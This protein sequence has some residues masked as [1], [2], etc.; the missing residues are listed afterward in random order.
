M[1]Q[2]N[3]VNGSQMAVKLRGSYYRGMKGKAG[4]LNLDLPAF[5][6]FLKLTDI[7]LFQFFCRYPIAK[8][9]IVVIHKD[10]C[11]FFNEMR[12]QFHILTRHFSTMLL[13]D[14][15]YFANFSYHPKK[16]IFPAVGADWFPYV[17]ILLLQRFLHLKH[18]ID[19]KII[20]RSIHH[21]YFLTEIACHTP[22]KLLTQQQNIADNI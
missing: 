18:F 7:G 11:Q 10:I 8:H 16:L 4:R 20:H 5:H 17:F 19:S 6:I 15:N 9:N 12:S 1:R 13:D 21:S 22:A 2:V 3:A 14:I